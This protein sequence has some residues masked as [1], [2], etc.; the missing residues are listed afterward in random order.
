MVSLPAC[1]ASDLL[2]VLCSKM[3]QII[4]LSSKMNN[5]FS[6]TIYCLLKEAI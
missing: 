3:Q 4:P 1:Q 2:F 6:G 5:Y